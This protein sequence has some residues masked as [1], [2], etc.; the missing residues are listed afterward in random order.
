MTH[1]LDE[2]L[3]VVELGHIAELLLY[4]KNADLKAYL[5]EPHRRLRLIAKGIESDELFDK[6]LIEKNMYL[7]KNN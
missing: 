7:A 5:N 4:N 6:L 3:D 2:L 1:S